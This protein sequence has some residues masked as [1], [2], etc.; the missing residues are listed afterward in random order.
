M[1]ELKEDRDGL[2]E[3]YVSWKNDLARVTI[4]NQ[5]LNLPF[6]GDYADR[7]VLMFYIRPLMYRLGIIMISYDSLK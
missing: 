5:R 7:R 3:A 1:P 6:M 4:G 2:A